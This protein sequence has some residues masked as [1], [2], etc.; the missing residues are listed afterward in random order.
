MNE[1]SSL[2]AEVESRILNLL[3]HLGG[4]LT[5]SERKEVTLFLDASEYGLALGTLS[6]ILVDE[7]KLVDLKTLIEI[8]DLARIMEIRDQGF[9]YHLRNLFEMQTARKDRAA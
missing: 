4:A 9:V 7:N 6:G 5:T 3:G 1:F 8:D 2:H